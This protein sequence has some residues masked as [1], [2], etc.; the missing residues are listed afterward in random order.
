M[1]RY[2][3]CFISD[4]YVE[5]AS[6]RDI[7]VIDKLRYCYI[8]IDTNAYLAF[9]NDMQAMIK[10]MLL[11]CWFHSLT[12]TICLTSPKDMQVIT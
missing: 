7:D 6:W 8:P 1:T 4:T 12:C 3:R 9:N 11:Q 2:L 10:S 5:N